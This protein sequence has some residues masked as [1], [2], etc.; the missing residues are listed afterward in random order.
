[1]M[2]HVNTTG[3]HVPIWLD[4]ELPQIGWG[5]NP[6]FPNQEGSFVGNIIETGDLGGI[7]MA[8]VTGP[9]GYFCEGS[10]FNDGVVAGRIGVGQANAPYKNAFAGM[11]S[12]TCDNNS[13]YV[14]GQY[15]NGVYKADGT[16]W[17]A[18][19]WKSLHVPGTNYLYQNGEPITVWRNPSYAPTFDSMYRYGFQPMQATGKSI[20][21]TN[22]NTAS[23]TSVQQW[24]TWNGDSQKFAVL[25]GNTSSRWNIAMKLNTSKCLGP[26]TGVATSG[27]P[28]VV[29]DCNRSDTQGF[30][31]TADANTGAFTF[32]SA[33]NPSVCLDMTGNNNSDGALLELAACNGQNNQKF[34]VT[35]AY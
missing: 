30:T 14:T 22:A 27:T 9:A 20:D 11:T 1:M 35:S 6:S 18:D 13:L 29:Q 7:G 31:V 21:V 26:S 4:S 10:N 15:S 17:P 2:A 12:Q 25:A 19:G 23:G 5:T 24:D 32:A 8:G 16:R 33:A 28:I 34:K 3:V